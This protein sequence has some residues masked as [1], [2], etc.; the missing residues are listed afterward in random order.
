MSGRL[1]ILQAVD[2]HSAD[3]M[4]QLTLMGLACLY[5]HLWAVLEVMECCMWPWEQSQ[6]WVRLLHAD[7]CTLHAWQAV[8]HQESYDCIG[9]ELG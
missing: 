8:A 9:P 5:R 1:S 2:L 3:G 7:R 4:C 6:H